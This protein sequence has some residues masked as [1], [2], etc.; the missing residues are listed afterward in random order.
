M[1]SQHI[2]IFRPKLITIH[3][4]LLELSSRVL[5]VASPRSLEV[6]ADLMKK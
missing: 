3:I 6:C 1:S 2:A 4:L 5:Q